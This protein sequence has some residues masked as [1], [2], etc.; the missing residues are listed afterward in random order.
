MFDGAC[1]NKIVGTEYASKHGRLVLTLAPP[2]GSEFK[3]AFTGLAAYLL[4]SR[5]LGREIVGFEKTDIAALALTD[6]ERFQAADQSGTWP[7]ELPSGPE[8]VAQQVPSLAL[9]AYKIELSGCEPAWVVSKDF[10]LL[11]RRPRT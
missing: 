11:G 3:V 4:R 10:V 5:Q 1:G 6:W 8:G 7:A 2:D 9:K